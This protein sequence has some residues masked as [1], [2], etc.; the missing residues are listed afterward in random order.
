MRGRIAV[1]FLGMLAAAGVVLFCAF[2]CG[3]KPTEPRSGEPRNYPVYTRGASGVYSMFVFYPETRLLDTIDDPY[4]K[5][6]G[7]TV[8]ADGRLIYL[9]FRDSV[10]VLDTDSLGI[11]AVLPF[12]AAAGVAVSP[13]NRLIAFQGFGLA[14]LRTTDY[15]LVYTDTDWVEDGVFSADSRTFYGVG[16][17]EYDGIGYVYKVCGLPSSPHVTRKRLPGTSIYFIIP[18]PDESKLL[19]HQRYFFQVYDARTDSILFED[20]YW[21]GVGYLAMTPNGRLAFYTNPST[22]WWEKGT[23]HVTVF[24]IE[25]NRILTTM[26]T[27]AFLDTLEPLT[28]GV[29]RM[30]VTPDM[31]WLVA[32]YGPAAHQLLLFDLRTMEMVY[33]HAF[34]GHG[35]INTTVQLRR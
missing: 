30:V 20:A 23:T 33:F 17:S 13:D 21:P 31:R 3:D 16:G 19:A 28:F 35:M 34:H 22:P 26:G 24:D 8:S 2:G 27:D 25:A 12:G 4:L 1:S 14:I 6:E 32:Q 5:A 15:S 10:V 18:T 7:L 29:G 9:A 11:Q